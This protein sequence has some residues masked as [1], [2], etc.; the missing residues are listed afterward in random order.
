MH[1]RKQRGRIRLQGAGTAI[2]QSP[3]QASGTLS[4]VPS[5]SET[6][7]PQ[8][9]STIFWLRNLGAFQLIGQYRRSPG[10]TTW[11]RRTSF[12]WHLANRAAFPRV[13]K[14]VLLRVTAVWSEV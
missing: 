12:G 9:R 7:H 6:A 10:L 2:S 8:G 14:Q 4:C 3:V 13:M 11:A 5:L 1:P